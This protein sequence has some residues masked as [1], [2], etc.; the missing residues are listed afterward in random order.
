MVSIDSGT[1]PAHLFKMLQFAGCLMAVTALLA[2][3]PNGIYHT[4]KPGQTLYRIA[5]SYHVDAV[6]LAEINRIK[7]PRQLRVGQ[8][9]Y[10]PGASQTVRVPATARQPEPA[11]PTPG[12]DSRVASSSSKRSTPSAPPAVTRPAPQQPAPATA[13]R[14]AKGRFEWPL[15]GRI[16]NGFGSKGDTAHKGIEIAAAKGSS[17]KAAAPGKVIYSGN[18]IRGYGNLIILEHSDNYFTVY[19]YNQKNLVTQ[20]DFVGKGD[21]IALSG[22]PPNGKSPR[23]HFE[24]RRGKQ[25]VDPIFYLP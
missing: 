25:A 20:N 6:E 17:V 13:N 3:T 2:C 8:R 15:Q 21:R 11:R 23:L 24:I 10:I 18:A 19:G 7:D 22:T 4:V 12:R 16:L 14:S 9:L 5:Q 1:M